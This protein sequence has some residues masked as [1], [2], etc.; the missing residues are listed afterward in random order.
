MSEENYD[1]SVGVVANFGDMEPVP[2][3]VY[4]NVT[5][6]L[7]FENSLATTNSISTTSTNKLTFSSP[8]GFEKPKN[9]KK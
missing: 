3:I 6:S 1:P 5:Q 2:I 7:V 8:A 4:D 9:S